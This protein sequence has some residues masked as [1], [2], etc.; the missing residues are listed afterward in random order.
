MFKRIL[1]PLDG[2]QLAEQALAKALAIARATDAELNLMRVVVPLEV[3]A[4]FV[5]VQHVYDDTIHQQRNEAQAYLEAVVEH[6]QSDLKKPIRVE[7]RL[8][9]VAETIID[10][11]EEN[12]V[13]LIVMCSHGRTG[14]S[15]WVYGSI[16]EKVLRGARCDTLVV[17]GQFD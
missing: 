12:D 4:P 6:L 9:M 10:C 5:E 2:S 16:A 1:V 17:R 7:A 8:G 15:R 3:V 13:D 11:A 14:F